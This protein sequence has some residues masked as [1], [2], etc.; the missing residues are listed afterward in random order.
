MQGR[1]Q[2]SGGPVET[3]LP[4]RMKVVGKEVRG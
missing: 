1:E 3:G 2:G 4:G